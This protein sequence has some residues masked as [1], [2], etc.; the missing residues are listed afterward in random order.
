MKSFGPALCPC[1]HVR[2][3]KPH[4]LKPFQNRVK[5][6]HVKGVIFGHSCLLQHLC[7]KQLLCQSGQ[8]FGNG[9]GFFVILSTHFA[10]EIQH[11]EVSDSVLC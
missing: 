10:E 3:N 11:D 6:G 1:E 5:V 9:K 4:S 2:V 7:E 8:H